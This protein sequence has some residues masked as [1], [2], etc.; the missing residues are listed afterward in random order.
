MFS[1]YMRALRQFSRDVRL[2]LFSAT[3]VGF[4]FFGIYMVLLN[5]YLLRLGHKPDAIGLVHATGSLATVVFAVLAGSLGRRMGSRNAL[6]IGFG[7]FVV[8][9]GLLPLG[10]ILAP[11]WRIG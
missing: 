7:L 2:F 9:V 6:A 3:L 8:G 4:N 11:A 1:D 5:L 10:Q